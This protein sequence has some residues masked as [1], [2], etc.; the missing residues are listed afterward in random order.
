M[1]RLPVLLFFDHGPLPVVARL[2]SVWPPPQEKNQDR[3]SL[4]SEALVSYPHADEYAHL[5]DIRPGTP[6]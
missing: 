4:G 3:F 5:I 1:R 2:A 6:S